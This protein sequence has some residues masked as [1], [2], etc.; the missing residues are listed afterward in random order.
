MTLRFFLFLAISGCLLLTTPIQ[1]QHSPDDLEIE[2]NRHPERFK[3]LVAFAPAFNMTIEQLAD[4]GRV[5]TEGTWLRSKS[6]DSHGTYLLVEQVYQ[7]WDALANGGQG[8]W[9]SEDRTSFERDDAGFPTV[10]LVGTRDPD[11]GEFVPSFRRTTTRDTGNSTIENLD[12][13]WNPDANDGQGAYEPLQRSFLALNDQGNVVNS[14][15]EF[16]DE[17]LGAY[18]ILFRSTNTYDSSGQVLEERLFESAL[19][20]PL[21]PA[22]LTTYKYDGSGRIVEE[23]VKSYNVAAA[24]FEN[25]SLRQNTFDGNGERTERLVQAWDPVTSDWVNQDRRQVMFSP[26]SA[27]PTEIVE[28]DQIWDPSANAA[29]GDWLNEDRSTATLSGS[30]VI[31][32]DQVWDAAANDGQGDWLNRERDIIALDGAQILEIV[33]QIWDAAG[34]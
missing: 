19:F 18:V 22:L 6:S 27:S 30:E 2:S 23:L 24:A 4:R 29:Q 13:E 34:K 10:L 11:T 25:W 16:W 17:D 12:E 31:E 32:T 5:Q 33:S 8:G 15:T 1:G 14:I 7:A 20:G 3:Q 21:A 28:T 9:V 26:N